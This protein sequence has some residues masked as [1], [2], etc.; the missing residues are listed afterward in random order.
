MKATHAVLM[1]IDGALLDSVEAQTQSWLRVLHE[2]GYDI[3]YRQVRERIGL[4]PDRILREL[5]GISEASPRARRMLPIRRLLFSHAL[6]HIPVFPRALAFIQRMQESGAKLAIVTSASRSEA[7][8]LLAAGRLLTEFDHVVCREDVLR[9][10]PAPDGV[11]SALQ[12][13]G[14]FPHQALM[15]AAS[16]YD[17]AAANA[18]RVPCFRL[19]TG[20]WPEAMA[21][22]PVPEAVPRIFREPA[23]ARRAV[24]PS[25][26]SAR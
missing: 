25:Q 2:F 23:Q 15:I 21:L 11:L 9:T 5:C 8:S 14:V 12:R 24:R 18:A 17:V 13:L 1:D 10:K 20:I 7:L 22:G 3:D 4:G 19:R 16:P 26:P 6:P